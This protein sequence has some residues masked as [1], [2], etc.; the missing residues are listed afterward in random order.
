MIY[1]LNFAK[2]VGAKVLGITGRDGGYT[3]KIVD[4]CIVIPTQSSDTVKPHAEAWQ[5]VIWHID[6]Y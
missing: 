5:A 1:A 6:G 4:A 2:N 3:A